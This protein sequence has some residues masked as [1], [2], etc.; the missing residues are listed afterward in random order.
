[1]IDEMKQVFIDAED[2]AHFANGTEAGLT[3]HIF[4]IIPFGGYHGDGM[5]DS[6]WLIQKFIVLY[7]D[8]EAS[9]G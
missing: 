1:M 2:L 6:D 9:D 7:K 3:R 8:M 5:E 4:H